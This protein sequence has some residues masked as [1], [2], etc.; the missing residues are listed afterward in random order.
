MLTPWP[1][2]SRAIPPRAVVERPSVRPTCAA[3][4]A[5]GVLLGLVAAVHA[6][7]ATDGRWDAKAAAAYLDARQ[8]WWA[9]WPTAAR[10][11]GTFCVSCHTVLPYALARPALRLTLAE[12]AP[13]PAESHLIDNV[14]AR[15]TRWNEMA[16]YYPDQTRGIPKTSE[17]RGTEAIFN[18]LILAMRDRGTGRLENDTQLAFDHMW[19]LQM[20]TGDLAGA[21]AWLNFHNEPWESP[22]SAYF[23]AAIAAVAVGSAPVP[24]AASPAIQ[25]NLKRLRGYFDREFDHQP[26]SNRLVLMWASGKVE[27]LMSSEQRHSVADAAFGLQRQDGGWSFASLGN[28][29]RAD[30]TPIETDSDGYATGLA[31]L[32]LESAGVPS[33]DARLQRGLD[34]LRAHQ[35]PATGRWWA[36]SP[37]KRRDPQSDAARFMSDAATAFAVLALTGAR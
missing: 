10:D 31:V 36:S 12:A 20:K 22:T 3:I 7:A 34:W 1:S 15:V 23:G 6:G 19:D 33:S 32:A 25:D 21:W 28:F 13:T 37:N 11:H 14:D 30:G 27:G 35:D 2:I 8:T 24:Y 5:A 9:A 18:A 4:V 29:S 17:S 26:L 16:P